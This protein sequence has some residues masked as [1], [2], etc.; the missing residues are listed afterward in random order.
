MFSLLWLYS[1]SNNR[2]HAYCTI[3][4]YVS[5]I[6]PS[7]SNPGLTYNT[8]WFIYSLSKLDRN[9]KKERKKERKQKEKETKIEGGN[10]TVYQSW[11]IEIIRE[12]GRSLEKNQFQILPPARS[13]LHAN[14]PELGSVPTRT[15][16]LAHVHI[17][18]FE[19]SEK[20][21][22]WRERLDYITRK[23]R[24]ISNV[25]YPKIMG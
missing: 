15:I 3:H 4:K 22:F 9:R 13:D 11:C 1:L 18:P 24:Y 7:S 16:I 25:K 12:I 20:L 5:V 19:K 6:Y 21:P 10:R 17:V 2:L 8:F 14:L 23:S